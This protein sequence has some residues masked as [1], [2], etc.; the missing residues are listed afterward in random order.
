LPYF[1]SKRFVEFRYKRASIFSRVSKAFGV[2]IGIAYQRNA[3]RVIHKIV[4][5]GDHKRG[6]GWENLR[7][8]FGGF[9]A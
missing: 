7:G 1:V 6:V 4:M 9:D 3:F 5:S 8:R 2:F